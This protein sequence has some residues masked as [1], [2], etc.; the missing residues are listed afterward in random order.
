MAV[1]QDRTVFHVVDI[2]AYTIHAVSGFDGHHIVDART[3][4]APVDKVDGLVAAI[5]KEDVALGHLLDLRDKCLQLTLQRVGIA[6]ERTIVG[7]LVGIEKHMGIV[8]AILV[9][10]TAVGRQRPDIGPYKFL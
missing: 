9:A 1:E 6:V 4:E 3:G 10:G 5:A 2:G 8:P 7:I